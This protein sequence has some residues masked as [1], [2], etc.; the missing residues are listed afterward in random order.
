MATKH[1]DKL[2]ARE[3]FLLFMTVLLAVFIG[4]CLGMAIN[5]WAWNNW[6]A[7]Q[8]YSPL[9]SEPLEWVLE[10]VGAR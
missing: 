5:N 10:A 1:D 6:L 7:E 4:A 8:G 2:T 9:E 3:L